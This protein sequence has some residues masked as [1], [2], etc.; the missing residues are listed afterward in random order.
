MYEPV[1]IG[2][3]FPFLN[4]QPWQIRGAPKMLHLSQTMPK[5]LQDADMASGDILRKLCQQMWNLRTMS[6]DVVRQV[7]YFQPNHSILCETEGK[8]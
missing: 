7:L 6:E 5:M 4:V 3:V 1:T 2:I 8:F